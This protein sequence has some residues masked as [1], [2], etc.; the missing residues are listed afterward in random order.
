MERRPCRPFFVGLQ[1]VC[2]T[3]AAFSFIG[4]ADRREAVCHSHQ[5][6]RTDPRRCTGGDRT[7]MEDQPFLRV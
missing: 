3:D 5:A 1:W 4:D 7:V 6:I 2:K